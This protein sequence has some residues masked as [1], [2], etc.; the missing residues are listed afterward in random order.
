MNE[1]LTC[2]DSTADVRFSDFLR[3]RC[4]VVFTRRVIIARDR[5]QVKNKR[6]T[7]QPE[8]INNK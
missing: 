6:D 8:A 4:T 1:N 7:N 3:R 2:V 5:N